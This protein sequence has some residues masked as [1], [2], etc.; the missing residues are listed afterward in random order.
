MEKGRSYARPKSLA[1]VAA[2]SGTLAE[3]GSNLRDWQHEIQRGGI[4]SRRAF[5][6]RIAVPPELLCMRFEGGDV[7]DAYLAG[8][9]EWLA[10]EAGIARPDWCSSSQR[11]AERPWFASPLRGHLLVASPASFRQRQIFTIPE[12]V[13]TPRP[14]R[15]P[16]SEAHR[17][18]GARLRQKA[19]RERIAKLVRKARQET[20]T[21]SSPAAS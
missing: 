10:D 20:L 16:V 7:A 5:A 3:F 4:H 6:Q 15:P 8:Y 19:Y 14:G 1:D 12:R 18:E 11:V 2:Q 9:A 13:F 21:R 17:R